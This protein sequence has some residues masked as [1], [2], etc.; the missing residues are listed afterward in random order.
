MIR[1][2]TNYTLWGTLSACISTPRRLFHHCVK[3]V[4]Q[5]KVTMR[6]LDPE[7]E[8]GFV[9]ARSEDLRRC[10]CR[11]ALI[12]GSL[13]W[14][15]CLEFLL[16]RSL[17]MNEYPTEEAADVQRLSLMFGFFIGFVLMS[18]AAAVRMPCFDK[19]LNPWAWEIV[20]VIVFVGIMSTIVLTH[21]FYLSKL[22]GHDP[23]EIFEGRHFSDSFILLAID[24][25]VT[26]THI[27]LPVRWIILMPLELSG[28]VLYV[29][30]ITL[31]GS[32]ESNTELLALTGVIAVSALGKRQTEKRDREA[33]TE[34]VKEKSLR[35]AAEFRLACADQHR[36]ATK[37][38]VSGS[39]PS[40]RSDPTN[41]SVFEGLYHQGADV[42]RHLRSLVGLGLKEHWLLFEEEVAMT[43]MVLG[44]GGYGVVKGGLFF[45]TKVAVKKPRAK[46]S[47]KCLLADF[48]NELR[49]LRH[50]RH[51]N[52]VLLHG[53]VVD[54]DRL[55]V[56]LVFEMVDGES[57][58]SFISGLD[59]VK[60]PAD[61][62]VKPLQGHSLLARHQLVAGICHALWYL[63]SRQPRIV[64]GDLKDSNIMVEASAGGV[65]P[66]LL[67]FGL[68]RILSRNTR[69]SGGTLRWLAPEVFQQKGKN[70]SSK[71]DV[72]SLG[73]LMSFIVTG[74]RPMKNLSAKGMRDALRSGVVPPVPWPGSSV[75]ETACRPIAEQCL[76]PQPE[77]RPS[78]ETVNGAV[79]QWPQELSLEPSGRLCQVR[80]LHRAVDA[81]KTR[82][83]E[84]EVSTD[85][86]QSAGEE[87]GAEE[88]NVSPLECEGAETRTGAND[89]D[90]TP[91]RMRVTAL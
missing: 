71:A 30:L 69:P 46:V 73:H 48:C 51:P 74:I 13:A 84:D 61:G 44:K 2:E 56:R 38:R 64:H 7:K 10:S 12:I 80:S 50:V 79:S 54:S 91:R 47:Q 55:R 78:M 8:S 20:A 45:G 62:E 11:L 16:F 1:E 32:P 68:S 4:R 77:Q 28:V 72:F 17:T 9:A 19:L 29:L 86:A 33:F 81:P 31:L 88:P 70:P 59:K 34:L 41:Q 67:D 21:V 66:K 49:V 83:R 23:S 60:E 42:E 5:G 76:L 22:L 58:H 26:A 87:E 90:G 36:D 82:N 52:V 18:Y 35:C 3:Y 37:A 14:V 57:L 85:G 40:V 27:V 53:A 25:I 39:D 65:R 75:Y 24:G 6:F 63:H 15:T 43:R 89:C